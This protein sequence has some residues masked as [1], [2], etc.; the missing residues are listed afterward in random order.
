[1][2]FGDEIILNKHGF[3]ISNRTLETVGIY[4]GSQV[5]ILPLRTF[6]SREEEP[7]YTFDIDFLLSPISP[8]KWPFVM[9]FEV[10]LRNRPGMLTKALEFFANQ[11]INILF[12][13]CTRSGHHHEVLNIVGEL[14]R[15]ENRTLR[16]M[17]EELK[18]YRDQ[19]RD[20]YDEIYK[21]I[22]KDRDNKTNKY[23]WGDIF[24]KTI[25]TKK[26][27]ENDNNNEPLL[28]QDPDWWEALTYYCNPDKEITIE[29]NLKKK[30]DC[31]SSKDEYEL[32]NYIKKVEDDIRKGIEDE[33]EGLFDLHS[34][35]KG[36]ELHFFEKKL[37]DEKITVQYLL[38]KLISKKRPEVIEITNNNNISP[39]DKYF[40]IER[41]MVLSKLVL[42]VILE[43]KRM[44]CEK[45]KLLLIY[46]SLSNEPY[47]FEKNER[48]EKD[49]NGIY[50]YNMRYF[51]SVYKYPYFNEKATFNSSI[52]EDIKLNLN[53]ETLSW[54]E[55]T[56]Q[57]IVKLYNLNPDRKSLWVGEPRLD[58][59]PI[60]IAPIEYLCHA[61]YH[62]VYENSFF[63]FSED[64]FIPFPNSPFKPDC[65]LKEIL[66]EDNSAT[67]A[68]LSRN[69]DSLMLRLCPIPTNRL[70]SFKR[71]DIDEYERSCLDKCVEN[72]VESYFDKDMF[73]FNESENTYKFD[74]FFYQCLEDKKVKLLLRKKIEKN[75]K[76]NNE[77]MNRNSTLDKDYINELEFIIELDILKNIIPEYFGSKMTFICKFK[78]ELNRICKLIDK[79][80]ILDKNKVV[81][82][83]DE[84]DDDIKYL[85]TLCNYIQTNAKRNYK[86]IKQFITDE[87][88][89]HFY[90]E[91]KYVEKH[92]KEIIK[93][94]KN[95]L[96]FDDNNDDYKLI[97]NLLDNFIIKLGEYETILDLG[98][99]KDANYCDA[100]TN[101]LIYHLTDTITEKLLNNNCNNKD[102]KLNIWRAY[103]KTFKLSDHHEHGS[104]QFIAQ[105]IGKNF[106]GFDVNF[107]DR[108]K[109]ILKCKARQI[110]S[111][112]HIK[113]NKIN[114][115]NLSG[116]RVFISMPLTHSMTDE[117][118]KCL[119]VIGKEFGF[120][121]IDTVESYTESLT[122]LVAKRI[123][124]SHAMIQIVALEEPAYRFRDKNYRP[125][126]EK[127]TWIHAEYLVAIN[128]GLKIIRLVDESSMIFDELKIGRDHAAMYFSANK[129]FEKFEET[130]RNAYE[131]LVKELATTLGLG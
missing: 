32:Y 9:R 130:V 44:L 49:S 107:N 29:D 92:I 1:M 59:D 14:K 54:D 4:K 22:Y 48:N 112:N 106:G 52:K 82:E 99:I 26:K 127:L 47:S 12:S 85:N 34:K 86:K 50:L 7:G 61:S 117:W 40:E 79:I 5:H 109:E 87:N 68:I 33:R 25:K 30:Y 90:N 56:K 19:R 81:D 128:E 58:L 11:D 8:E 31:Y 115:G 126:Y 35:L 55:L 114:V 65:L 38:E 53:S 45:Y 36:K 78:Y 39:E 123:K 94:T 110:S 120:A 13:E 98:V 63:T 111:S 95:I 17:Y 41:I 62:R 119:Q 118:R 16:K 91:K 100:T 75:E 102:Y 116:G 89:S 125:P 72:S 131:F 104:I 51:R 122:P 46:D 10:Y 69:T 105:G 24:E 3:Q 2:I 67:I 23:S 113:L 124:E 77:N 96:N 73:K 20:I 37:G 80:R 66:Q 18:L 28:A 70:K 103:D 129:P 71:I 60:F 57:V 74:S 76:D 97:Q 21:T 93:S 43:Y 88:D 108:T 84:F 6:E 15:L 101:G 27:N 64:S 121:E 42:N 83:N